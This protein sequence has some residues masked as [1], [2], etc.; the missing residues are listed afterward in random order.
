MSGDYVHL[1]VAKILKRTEAA[2]LVR[3]EDGS[4]HWLP[5]SQVSDESDYDEGD[6]DCTVS[7]TRWLAEQR[8]LVP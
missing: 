7:I 4:E 8:G 3:L 6:L 1:D 2:L 5:L